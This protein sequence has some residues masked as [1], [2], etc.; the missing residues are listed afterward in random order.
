MK[1]VLIVI[2]IFILIVVGFF[3][4][5]T[6]YSE[7]KKEPEKTNKNTMPKSDEPYKNEKKIKSNFDEEAEEIDLKYDQYIEANGYAGASDNAYYTRNNVLYHIVL[8]SNE[9]TRIAEGIDKIESDLDCIKA[10]KGKNF[11]IIEE[12]EYVIYVNNKE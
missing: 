11:K 1:K 10:Y 12:D 6:L 5:K 4:Y 8:S 2:I 9:T 7:P 3:A